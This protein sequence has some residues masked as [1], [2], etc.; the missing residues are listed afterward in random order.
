[1]TSSNAS[2][3][4]SMFAD[5]LE[6]ISDGSQYNLSINRSEERYN[7]RDCIKQGQ[8]ECKGA[9]LS[10]QNMDKV[11]YKLFKAVVKDIW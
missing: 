9:L 5:M 6:Y 1:M 10:A 8:A 11:L 7:I 2:D 3:V 4:A